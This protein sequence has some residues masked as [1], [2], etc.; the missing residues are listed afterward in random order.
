M[1]RRPV[2]DGAAGLLV[3]DHFV[4]IA[5][6]IVADRYKE[7]RLGSIGSALTPGRF[8]RQTEEREIF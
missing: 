2:C 7:D 5:L 6:E 1:V 8:I 3:E 4:E